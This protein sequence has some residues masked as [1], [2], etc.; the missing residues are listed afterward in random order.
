MLSTIKCITHVILVIA[1]AATAITPIPN[2]FGHLHHKIIM[3][4]LDEDLLPAPIIHIAPFPG[5]LGIF[6]EAL[7]GLPAGVLVPDEVLEH[8]AAAEASKACAIK[9]TKGTFS[10]GFDGGFE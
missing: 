9:W 8:K 5:T 1:T 4:C 2:N 7:Y 3:I 6:Q 10:G